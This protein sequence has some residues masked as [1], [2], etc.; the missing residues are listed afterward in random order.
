M[1]KEHFTSSSLLDCDSKLLLSVM[2]LADT[3]YT[4]QF[5]KRT[6]FT[7]M[8]FKLSFTVLYVILK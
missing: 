2:N 8:E 5:K 1:C 4:E 3:R 6:I 7:T